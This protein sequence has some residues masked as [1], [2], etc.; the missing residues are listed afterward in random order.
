MYN[1]GARKFAMVGV[2]AV[3]CCPSQRNKNSTEECSE[4]ANYWSVKYNERL[5]S[6]LQE[7]ISE[8]KGMSYSYFDTYSVMLNLI[9]K[10]AAYGINYWLS[11]LFSQTWHSRPCTK[12][13][14]F[15]FQDLKRLKLLVV[16]WGT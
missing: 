4:E 2:G 10:P 8:L 11:A 12:T 9:Q 16:G 13:F 3:G 6:L 7:L 15:L 1:L 14:L 5:K